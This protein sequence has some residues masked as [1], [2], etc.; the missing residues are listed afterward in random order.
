MFKNS[1]Q[2]PIK[3]TIKPRDANR[4]KGVKRRL[5]ATHGLPV[6]NMTNQRNIMEMGKGLSM[7][8]ANQINADRL[9][10]GIGR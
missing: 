2:T 4:L 1:S 6:A 8:K 10:V 7:T 5:R 9:W 3:D